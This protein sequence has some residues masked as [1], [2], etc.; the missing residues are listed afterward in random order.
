[1]TADEVLETLPVSGWDGPFPPDLQR[2]ATEALEAGRVLVLPALRFTVAA[3]E[4]R[5]L[6]PASLGG[7]RKNISL[8]PQR[9]RLGNSTLPRLAGQNIEYLRK[10]MADF[11][12]GARANNPWM[13]ALLETYS[14]ED[15]DALARYLAGL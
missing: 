15:I 13:K 11:R 4:Q 3:A 7:S 10:T 8:D 5:F 12:S 9:A 2:R 14:D 6:N 1:M